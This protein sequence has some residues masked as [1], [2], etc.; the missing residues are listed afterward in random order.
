ML[1]KLILAGTLTLSL[2]LFA[3]QSDHSKAGNVVVENLPETP[4]QVISFLIARK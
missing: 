1:E 3:P 4:S 2:A